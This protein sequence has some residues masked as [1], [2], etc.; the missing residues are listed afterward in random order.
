MIDK[1]GQSKMQ[2][3]IVEIREV[4][5]AYHATIMDVIFISELIKLMAYNGDFG[6][7]EE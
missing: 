4:Y 5:I 6:E 2:E 1:M 7:V 3:I